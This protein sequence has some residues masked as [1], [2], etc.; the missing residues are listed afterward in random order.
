MLI[1]EIAVLRTRSTRHIAVGGAAANDEA[2]VGSARR[3]SEG[4]LALEEALL[5]N[6]ALQKLVDA[7]LVDESCIDDP[8]QVFLDLGLISGPFGP[9]YLGAMSPHARRAVCST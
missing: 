1:T 9:A 3:G 4:R 5:R 7:I 6:C 8:E 2:A